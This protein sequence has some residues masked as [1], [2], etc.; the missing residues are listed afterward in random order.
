MKLHIAIPVLDEMEW[1]PHTME[2]LAGQSLKDFKVWVCVNQPDD[3]W[4][5]AEKRRICENNAHLLDWLS[6]YYDLDCE[7]I[8]RSSEGKGWPERKGESVLP[9]NL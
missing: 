3:W 1:L 5:C 8:D 6:S 7:V 2:S 9:V 4:N